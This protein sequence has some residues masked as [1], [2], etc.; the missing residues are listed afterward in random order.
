MRPSIKKYLIAVLRFHGDVLLTTPVIGAI[1]RSNPNAQIDLLV[2]KDTGNILQYD[3]R[4]NRI[5]EV[6]A[7][8]RKNIFLRFKKELRLWSLLKKSKYDFAL[9]LTTQWRLALIGRI[10]RKTLSSAVRDKKRE[11]YLWRGSF[12][13]LFSEAGQNHIV[14]RNLIG[15]SLLGMQIKDD[16]KRLDLTIPNNVISSSSII[17]KNYSVNPNYCV[18]HPCSRRSYK[19]WSEHNFIKVI[20]YLESKKIQ[21]ILS[22]GPDEFEINYLKAIQKD[23][24]T[25]INLGGKTSLLELAYII[26][27]SNFFLGLD[28]VASHISAAVDTPSISLFGPTNPINWRPWSDK[29]KIISR[30]KENCSLHGSLEGKNKDCLCSISSE[31]VIKAIDEILRG[32]DNFL[33]N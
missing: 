7:S 14:E 4:I 28:S 30:T 26:R 2:Y 23:C 20:N 11:N 27:G 25:A 10:L 9:F 33:L 6:E 12:S 24:P 3:K 15:L 5:I 8:S 19:L 17:L 1:K 32:S 29:S 22:S 18:I 16:D 31:R 21:V 13:A